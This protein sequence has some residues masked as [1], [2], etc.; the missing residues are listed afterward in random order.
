[1]DKLA[2]V[3]LPL[4][5]AAVAIAVLAWRRRLPSR[6]ALN[7]A[8]SLLLLMYLAATAGL[9]IFWVANQHLPVF[10]WHYLFGYATV[11]L[12]VVHLAFNF[13]VVWNFLRRP[14]PAP[15]PRA[16]AAGVVPGRR[17]V[18]GALGVVGGGLALA[19]A[20]WFGL[21]HGRTELRIE[22][23][24]GDAR[25][26]AD[27]GISPA[28]ALALV[29]Q[30]HE[31]SSHS[32]SGVFRRA[33]GS[34]WGDP[35]PPFKT[36]PGAASVALAPA[37]R[38][39]AAVATGSEPGAQRL[40]TLL[41]MV[42]GVSEWRGGIPFRT[43]PSSGALFATELYL[44]T[45]ESVGSGADR[46]DPGL[47]HYE[48]RGHALERL[49]DRRDS[50]ASQPPPPGARAA[51]VASAIFRRSGHKY[52]DRTYRYVLA[53]LGHALENLRAAAAALGLHAV[54]ETAFN[55]APWSEA[56]A[57]DAAE[58]GV[59]ALAWLQPSPSATSAEAPTTLARAGPW[60]APLPQTD[61]P[62]GVTDAVHR[63]TALRPAGSST[64]APAPVSA[65]TSQP[66]SSPRPGVG[67]G[68]DVLAVL[69]RRRSQR[70]YA[71]TPLPRPA[72]D[73]LV[74][75]LH[76]A[77]PLLSNAVRVHLVA[78]RVEDLPAGA[79]RCD[80]AGPRLE[81]SPAALAST[82]ASTASLGE[83]RRRSRATGLDQD[84][85]G[86]AAAV[87]V[88][89]IARSAWTTDPAGAARGYRHAFL[90]AGFVGERLYLAA[91]TLSLGVGV[92]AVGAYYDDEAAA[93]IGVDG[94]EEWPVHFAAVGVL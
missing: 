5:G 93:L 12:L 44:L 22:A 61:A 85:I 82:L 80:P 58:E 35:P 89:T 28:T 88:L 76:G 39:T 45:L 42:A 30:F 14:R 77:G 86:D 31:F 56:L 49:P 7:V 16:M 73:R 54:F 52:R 48:P 13:R 62:L 6:L 33:P 64:P 27:T 11:L 94:R 19:G 68:A 47:W 10:D 71:D 57:L 24:A 36:M 70:R 43:S 78:H 34:A 67:L 9:G 41:W 17:P 90:E 2:W 92:C 29:Q 1:M 53:D 81:R 91:P 46:L 59:L 72:L 75:A 40:G 32:R 50:L 23:A 21:R 55:D 3:M 65:M 87:F 8:F 25:E 84:V 51:I 20:Y 60:R 83:L 4:A 79:W 66:A 18:V 26:R 63:A 69:A 74:A 37:W 15:L 38:N